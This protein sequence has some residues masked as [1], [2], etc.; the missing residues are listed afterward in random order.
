MV[1]YHVVQDPNYP[2]LYGGIVVSL[3]DIESGG[4]SLTYRCNGHTWRGYLSSLDRGV[5][6]SYILVCPD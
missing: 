2:T 3:R 6:R 5:S 4:M 1:F